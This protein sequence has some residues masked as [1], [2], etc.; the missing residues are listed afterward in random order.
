MVARLVLVV[1]LNRGWV[2]VIVGFAN[3][4]WISGVTIWWLLDWVLVVELNGWF[5][6]GGESL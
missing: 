6:F 4:G 1:E 5:G 3:G 2:L